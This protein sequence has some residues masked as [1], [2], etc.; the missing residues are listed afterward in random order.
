MP[1]HIETSGFA[2]TSRQTSAS[3]N[4]CGPAPQRPC[5]AIEIGLP[6]WSIVALVKR[7]GE[8]IAS[9]NASRSITPAE[10]K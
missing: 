2:P 4:A 8:P 10:Q 7:I 1:P 6:G 3:A 5:R 9:M